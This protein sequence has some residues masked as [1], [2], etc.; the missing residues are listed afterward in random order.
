MSVQRTLVHPKLFSG[1]IVEDSL[2]KESPVLQD[3]SC[4]AG[5]QHRLFL[6]PRSLTTEEC[7][8]DSEGIG[9]KDESE[10]GRVFCTS[11]G[12]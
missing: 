4:F 1:C 11:P 8:E 10:S 3:P 6:L 12:V 9:R 7:R 5:L 2:F